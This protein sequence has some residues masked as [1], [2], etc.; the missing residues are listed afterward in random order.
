MRSLKYTLLFLISLSLIFC[1]SD[2]VDESLKVKS[3]IKQV[4]LSEIKTPESSEKVLE[5]TGVEFGSM[6]NIDNDIEAIPVLSDKKAV[7]N[8]KY[9]WFVN[10]REIKGE[11]GLTLSRDYLKENDWVFCRVSIQEE[12]E[13]YPEF[14]SKLIKVKGTLPLVNLTMVEKFDSPGIFRYKINAAMPKTENDEQDTEEEEIDTSGAVRFE[15]IFPL[16][17]GIELNPLTGEIIWNITDQIIEELGN[18]VTI[19]FS[20]LSP[21]GRKVNASISLI[22]KEGGTETSETDNG[23]S[24]GSEI[25]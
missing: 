13:S 25:E 6:I 21:S 20:V 24:M 23:S 17:K 12:G 3:R 8:Y 4:S 11:T 19:K 7:K 5:I 18:K 9:R 2:E 1:G 15:L 14:K 16:E 22:L 10:E